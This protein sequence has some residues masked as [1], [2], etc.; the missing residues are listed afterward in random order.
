MHRWPLRNLLIGLVLAP[1][2]A[3]AQTM[4]P[5]AGARQ[6]GAT[7]Y[8]HTVAVPSA[9]AVRRE[10]RVVLDGRLDEPAWRNR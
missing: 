2:T 4:P 3:V 5:G 1:L 10:G 8:G 9:L 7:N 6:S